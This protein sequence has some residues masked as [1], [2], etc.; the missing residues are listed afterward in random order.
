MSRTINGNTT[1]KAAHGVDELDFPQ[2]DL[3]KRLEI[4]SARVKDLFD[5]KL[6]FV[7]WM[8]HIEEGTMLETMESIIEQVEAFDLLANGEVSHPVTDMQETEQAIDAQLATWQPLPPTK[9][10][11]VTMQKISDEHDHQ[12]NLRYFGNEEGKFK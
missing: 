11:A 9:Y 6:F 5:D 12:F 1:G 8:M 7:N 2:T 4:A 10:G 3:E